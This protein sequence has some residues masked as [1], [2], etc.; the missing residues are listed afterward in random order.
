[1]LDL[2]GMSVGVSSVAD[3][4]QVAAMAGAEYF[5]IR[6]FVVEYLVEQG[7]ATASQIPMFLPLDVAWDF[8]VSTIQDDPLTLLFWG[9]A[10]WTAFRV[11][12]PAKVSAVPAPA[13]RPVPPA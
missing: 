10:V 6:H 8:V 5:I 4:T 12:A 7:S 2:V 9:I 11:P 3:S 13:A 1:M